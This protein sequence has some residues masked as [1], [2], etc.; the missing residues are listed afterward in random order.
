MTL[1]NSPRTTWWMSGIKC[2]NGDIEIYQKVNVI[3]L[4]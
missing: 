2:D 4:M 1:L 3:V